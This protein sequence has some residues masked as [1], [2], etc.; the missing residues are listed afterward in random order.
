MVPYSKEFQEINIDWTFGFHNGE[1]LFMSRQPLMG[2]GLLTVQTSQSHSEDSSGRVMTP[3]HRPLP[4]N[5]H[6]TRKRQMSMP[7]LRFEPTIP[8]NE[9]PQIHRLTPGGHRIGFG[10]ENRKKFCE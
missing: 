4:D 6:N 3:M 5:T 8:G 2:Q 10:E 7:P 9:Q 1:G